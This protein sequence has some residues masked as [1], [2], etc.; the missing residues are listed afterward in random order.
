MVDPTV[1]LVWGGEGDMKY[2][3][4]LDCMW[5]TDDKME[6]EGKYKW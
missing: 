6:T 5:S 3:F 4:L 1:L 2:D